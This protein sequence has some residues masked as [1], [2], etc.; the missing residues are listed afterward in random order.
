MP[1]YVN[2]TDRV[3]ED[4]EVV[5]V[6]MERCPL[7]GGDHGVMTGFFRMPAGT[8]LPRHHHGGWVQI[9]VLEGAMRVE[10]QDAP[11]RDVGPGGWYFVEPGDTHVETAVEDAVIFVTLQRDDPSHA[12][13]LVP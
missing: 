12:P 8:R 10:Q 5:G 6:K 3:W 4:A 1:R 9:L 7:W 13:V 11:S 2:V